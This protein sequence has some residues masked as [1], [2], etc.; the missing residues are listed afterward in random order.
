MGM[1]KGKTRTIHMRLDI[2]GALKNWSTKDF[3]GLLVDDSGTALPPDKAKEFLFDELAKG[4]LYMPIGECDNFDPKQ[5]CLGHE[6]EG[7]RP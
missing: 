6:A 1:Q 4:N 2:K 7:P 5:G 3:R